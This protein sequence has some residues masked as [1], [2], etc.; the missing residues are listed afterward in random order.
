MTAFSL[1]VHSLDSE[2]DCKAGAQSVAAIFKVGKDEKDSQDET[3]KYS[4][5]QKGVTIGDSFYFTGVAQYYCSEEAG[6]QALLD[7]VRTA[8]TS[9]SSQIEKL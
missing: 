7:K 5:T 8:F 9:A 6:K 4:E 1:R 2:A 3:K